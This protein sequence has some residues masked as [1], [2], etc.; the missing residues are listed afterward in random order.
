[1][2]KGGELAAD[3]VG[4]MGGAASPW[5]DL[6]Q[7]LLANLDALGAF[8]IAE[9]LG[10]SL[11]LPAMAESCFAIGREKHT[12]QLLIMEYMLEMGPAAILYKAPV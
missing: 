6:R 4:W 7:L 1:M 11:G 8:S 3:L 2:A 12:H 9:Q 10:Y 5:G